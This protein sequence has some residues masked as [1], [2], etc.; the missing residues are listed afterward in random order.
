MDTSRRLNEWTVIGE[1]HLRQQSGAVLGSASAVECGVELSDGTTVSN[2]HVEND[3]APTCEYVSVC[4][5]M[6]CVHTADDST[7]LC[8]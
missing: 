2:N 6:C 4:M 3:R 1:M 7:L 8:L 5:C